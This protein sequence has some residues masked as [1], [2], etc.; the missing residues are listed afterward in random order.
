M[1]LVKPESDPYHRKRIIDRHEL[2]YYALSHLWRITKETPYKWDDIGTYVDDEDGKPVAPVSMRPEK[3]GTLLELLRKHPDSY[4]WIDVL[5]ART[6]TPLDIMGDIYAYC[7]TC[8]TMIDCTSDI[9]SK[10]QATISLLLPGHEKSDRWTPCEF[11]QAAGVFDKFTQCDWWRR[12]W[13]WQEMAL[14]E[15]VCFIIETAHNIYDSDLLAITDIIESFHLMN[16]TARELKVRNEWTI[17]LWG[18]LV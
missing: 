9:I 8:Y 11:W 16:D 12:V 14:P 2:H 5:C 7:T 18:K 6:D 15:N 13:T 4:W 10:L 1:H 17:N 3:R